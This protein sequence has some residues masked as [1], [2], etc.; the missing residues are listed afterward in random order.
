MNT[1]KSN[2]SQRAVLRRFNALPPGK[3]LSVAEL[4]KSTASAAGLA[5]TLTRLTQRGK[6]ER[7]AKGHYRLPIAGRFGAVPPTEQQLLEAVLPSPRKRLEYRTG[8]AVF[9]QMGLTTQV[10]HTLVVATAKPRRPRQV[11]NL[12]VR[13]VRASAERAKPGDVA[14]CQLLDAIRSMKRIADSRPDATVQRLLTLVRDVTEPAHSRL[15][16]LALDYNPSTRALLGALLELAGAAALAERLRAT[17]NPLSRY[18]LGLSE[19]TLPNQKRW[20]IR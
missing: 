14:L 2:S 19:G 1:P 10:P 16:K 15:V 13:F 12:R 20:R 11:G 5:S 3:V 6:L 4:A 18:R 8:T 17:L 7:V 9:N